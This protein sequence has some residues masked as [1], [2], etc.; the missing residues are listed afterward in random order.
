MYY[1]IK[2][3][4]FSVGSTIIKIIFLQRNVRF[5]ALVQFIRP[6]LSGF[7][8]GASGSETCGRKRKREKERDE[9]EVRKRER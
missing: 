5:K 2:L 7:K 1:L 3:R 4:S 8:S 6:C 9:R